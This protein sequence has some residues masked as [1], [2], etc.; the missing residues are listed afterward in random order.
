MGGNN[1][2]CFN[3]FM[4]SSEKSI[5]LAGE[6]NTCSWWQ[7]NFTTYRV[8]CSASLICYSPQGTVFSW[9]VDITQKGCKSPHCLWVTKGRLK[10]LWKGKINTFKNSRKILYEE[11]PGWRT[12]MGALNFL[13]AM[14][15]KYPVARI[16]GCAFFPTLL[17]IKFKWA[18][19]LTVTD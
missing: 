18:W 7:Q 9:C 4:H 16:L 8:S 17:W 15:S 19:P 5:A 6:E 10:Y 12:R 3:Q 11:D 1:Q 13:L 2:F 14:E